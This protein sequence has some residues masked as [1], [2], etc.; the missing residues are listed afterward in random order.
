MFHPSIRETSSRRR[1]ARRVRTAIVA[2]GALALVGAVGIEATPTA[3]LK[4]ATMAERH[5]AG[6]ISH[7]FATTRH[8]RPLDAPSPAGTPAAPKPSATPSSA[9]TATPAPSAVASATPTP[10]AAASPAPSAQ[11]AAPRST[12]SGTGAPDPSGVPMPVGNLP[13]WT[14]VLAEDFTAPVAAGSFPGADASHW[15]SYNNFSDTSGD[16]WYDQ[17]IISSHDGMLD[18]YVHTA[19]GKALGAAP[20][21]LVNGT[22]GGQTYGRFSVRMRADSMPGYGAGFLLWP[23]SGNWKEGE[24]DFPEGGFNGAPWAYDHTI[25]NPSVN[26]VAYQSKM[27]FQDWHTYTIDWTPSRLSYEIDGVVVASTTANVPSTPF[28]WVMQVGTTGVV[29][30]ASVAGHVDIDWAT[31]YRYTP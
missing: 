28:H 22:W 18:L 19:G 17:S 9:A 7:R 25:G 5:P 29:P 20:V 15:M 10:S 27:S 13:G 31:I 6:T 1:R 2:A 8:A 14:Q 30:A 24:V 26:W 21:P 12:A 11:Q 23:D 16:G 3:A 4:A